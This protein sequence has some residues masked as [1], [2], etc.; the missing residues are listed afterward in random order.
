MKLSC[1]PLAFTSYKSF[2]KNKNRSGTSLPSLPSLSKTNFRRKRYEYIWVGVAERK[3]LD[4]TSQK[5]H[6]P[7]SETS[8]GF[9]LYYKSLHRKNNFNCII[10]KKKPSRAFYFPH[11]KSFLKSSNSAL[12]R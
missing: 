7:I 6:F 10:Q 11:N 12:F 9:A 4:S 8:F 1:R 2:L 3:D 5:S